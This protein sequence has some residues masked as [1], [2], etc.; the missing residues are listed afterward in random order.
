MA[1][2]N[3][4]ENN[5]PYILKQ[6]LNGMSVISIA[7]SLGISRAYVYKVLGIFPKCPKDYENFLDVDLQKGDTVVREYA[8]AFP[9]PA[10]VRKT[11]RDVVENEI[12]ENLSKK[13]NMSKEE[14]YDI[15]YRMTA[16]HPSAIHFPLYTKIEAW[17]T[18]KVLSLRDVA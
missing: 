2:Y 15:L 10:S 6:R 13:F 16:L 4:E 12:I 8:S 3:N 11:G 1:N 14:I 5:V 18:V 17:K 7:S 9:E